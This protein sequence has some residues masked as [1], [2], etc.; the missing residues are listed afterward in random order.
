MTDTWGDGWNGGY[1]YITGNGTYSEGSLLYGGYGV[2][3]IGINTICDG[4]GG[5]TDSTAVNYNPWATW[6]DGTC[7]YNDN[8]FNPEDLFGL[9]IEFTLY[10][11]PTNGGMILNVNN[12]NALEPV[13]IDVIG[14][15]GQAI[16][17]ITI[18][19]SETFRVLEFNAAD[20]APGFYIMNVKNGDRSVQSSFIR[21]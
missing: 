19:N 20:Y 15:T 11:N 17:S 6:D 14:I 9:D 13:V 4:I 7:L 18:A 12:L 16:E 21:Q 5:C 1:Y 2:D 8:G 3:N 10:P